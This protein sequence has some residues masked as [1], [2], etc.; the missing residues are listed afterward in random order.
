MRSADEPQH[1]AP[2]VVVTGAGGNIGRSISAALLDRYRVVGIDREASELGFPMLEADFTSDE[3]L[4]AV[5]ESLRASYGSRIA[6]VIH[7]VAFFDFSGEDNPL[8]QALNVEGIRRL[9][10]GLQSFEVEQFVYTSTM[11]VHAACSPGE[12]IDEDR[13]IEPR[14]AYPKSKADAEAVVRAEHGHMPYLLLR[15]AGVYDECSTVPTVAQQMARIYEREVESYFYSGNLR[16]GQSMLH[17]DDMIDAI[18]R[19][20]DQ[21]HELPPECALLIGEPDAIGYDALQDELGYL[22]HGVEDWPTLRIPKAVAT[23]GVIAQDTLEPI[24]P[25]AID[26]GERPFIKP[27]MIAMADDH[28]ELDVRRAEQLLGWKPRHRFKDELPAMVASLKRDPA[29]WYRR[30]GVEP[31]SWI[32]EAEE[33]G[34]RA[35]D[36]AQRHD[37]LVKRQ[38]GANRWAHLINMGLGT[39]LLTQPPLIQV[40]PDWLGYS[41]ISL[42]AALIVFAAIS[43]SWRGQWARWAQAGIGA[44][45][46]AVPFLFSTSNAAAYLSDTLVGALIFG[47]AVCT[48]PDVGPSPLAA[49]TGPEIPPGWDYNPST[50]TQRLPIIALAFLGLYVSRYLAA[51]Q[52]GHVDGVWEPFFE[53]SPTDP[54]NGT[55]EI[56]TSWVSEAWPVSDAAVGGYTYMLEI[57]TGIIGS[58]ARWRT[59][60]WLV[61][62]FGMMIVPLGVVS[63]FFIIIQPILIG[64][65]STL[66]LMAAAAML[67][68]IPYS[69]DELLAALQFVRRRMRAGQNALGVFLFGD[70]DETPDRP[71]QSSTDELDRPPGTLLREM[72]SGGVNVPWNLVLAALVGVSLLFTRVTIGTEGALANAHHLL[73]SLVLTVIAIAAAEVTRA[74]RYV[75]VLLGAAL[76]A[77]P[78]LYAG[79]TTSIVVSVACG[80]AIIVLSFR[81]GTIRGS[82]GDWDRLIR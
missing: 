2:L 11:L 37:A 3:S 32:T 43:L 14:W 40:E 10:R 5:L 74:V 48:K 24:I 9:L 42:G 26:K 19:A 81:R 47:L 68:Q 50:W 18:A 23:A 27:W 70:T 73:G 51:Y 25:D 64:T 35:G 22:I 54:R 29:A 58:R 34:E 57:L 66:A 12:R 1:D 39:W 33:I 52:L 61:V 38:L 16:V 44:L 67:V 17:R 7:L 80:L 20:V 49:L 15:L 13:R 21:R 56:V 55:E 62:L 28:Y 30:N 31:P 82:Y 72:V 69:I 41:E 53:G 71:A 60:P 65:W 78:F 77:V 36:I 4:S 76:I 45:V 8:Y 75:N 63:I 6:S 46:M 59:M 79:D